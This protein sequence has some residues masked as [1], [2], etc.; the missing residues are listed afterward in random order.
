MEHLPQWCW[1][2]DTHHGNHKCLQ[3]MKYRNAEKTDEVKEVQQHMKPSKARDYEETHEVN[4]LKEELKDLKEMK[5]SFKLK[6]I[7]MLCV[8]VCSIAF[9]ATKF[10]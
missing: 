4:E 9:V 7:A 1:I 2:Y 5:A 10:M 3:A 6:G 8:I